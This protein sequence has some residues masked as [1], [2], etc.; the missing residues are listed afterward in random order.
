MLVKIVDPSSYE[1]ILVTVFKNNVFKCYLVFLEKEHVIFFN[2]FQNYLFFMTFVPS[3]INPDF[4]IFDRTI[5]NFYIFAAGIKFYSNTSVLHEESP[6]TNRMSSK[7]NFNI[8]CPNMDLPTFCR[9][10][11]KIKPCVKVG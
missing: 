7:I 2:W 3:T 11:R 6:T 4:K 9:M 10:V 1:K 5:F 8:T